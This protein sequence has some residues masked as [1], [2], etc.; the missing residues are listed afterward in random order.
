MRKGREEDSGRAMGAQADVPGLT[1][2]SCG[3]ER[4]RSSPQPPH[5][6]AGGMDSHTF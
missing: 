5:L 2:A 4:A 1:V 6:T 3:L